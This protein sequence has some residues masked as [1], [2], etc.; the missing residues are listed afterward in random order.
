MWKKQL[1]DA[2]PHLC[3][4]RT[5]WKGTCTVVTVRGQSRLEVDWPSMLAD[6]AFMKLEEWRRRE[7]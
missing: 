7:R 2:D 1:I 4:K 5:K 6:F 3:R